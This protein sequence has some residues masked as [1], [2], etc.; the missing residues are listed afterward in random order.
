M[1]IKRKK[2]S[3]TLVELLVVISIIALIA[4]IILVWIY[5]ARAK[6]R[7]GKRISEMDSFRKALE[8]YQID[9]RKYPISTEWKMLE[10]DAQE[11][12]GA[13]G[14]LTQAI[15]P[16]LSSNLEDP[17][18]GET[19]GEKVFSYQY[20]S[21]DDGSE[22]KACVA[23]ELG[24]LY[25]VSSE[26]GSDLGAGGSGD[27]G[28][29]GSSGDCEEVKVLYTNPLTVNTFSFL[30]TSPGTLLWSYGDG[31]SGA[32]LSCKI[33]NYKSTDD[34]I[35][36]TEI[37]TIDVGSSVRNEKIIKDSFGNIYQSFSSDYKVFVYK[38]NDEGGSWNK[39]NEIDYTPNLIRTIY[40]SEDNGKIYLSVGAGNSSYIHRSS[41]QG[42]NWQIVK[43]V[44]SPSGVKALSLLKTVPNTLFWSFSNSTG[45]VTLYRSIDDGLTWSLNRTIVVGSN[46]TYDIDLYYSHD[47]VIYWSFV[48]N[49]SNSYLY[50]S[51]DQ[52]G[53]WENVYT[54]LTGGPVNMTSLAEDSDHNIYWSFISNDNKAY[55]YRFDSLVGAWDGKTISV[56][57]AV[58]REKFFTSTLNNSSF[59]TF[60]PSATFPHNVY[61]YYSPDSGVT[62]IEKQ[63]I[64]TGA[65][66]NDLGLGDGLDDNVYWFYGSGSEGH[67]YRCYK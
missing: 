22:Y 6:T 18:Y 58:L 9:A 57:G 14:E 23:L 29:A 55:L 64:A 39:V 4:S 8:V 52:G 53:N 66:I 37:N 13:G 48:S 67:L 35:S 19:E 43:Q 44:N 42:I 62:N 38:S 3:F 34:G 5:S 2:N 24:D 21:D 63:M 25:C 65:P 60:S 11:G 61:L 46:Y 36:W 54:I 31:Y 17:R 16:F 51:V 15:S 30:T 56:G 50:S 20:I 47:G 49:D 10:A 1:T 40:L 59:W 27:G 32:C 28:G 33:H 45:D 7:D 26:S 12:G 41:D